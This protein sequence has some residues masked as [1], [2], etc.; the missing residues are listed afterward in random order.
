MKR[1]YFLIMLGMIILDMSAQ[2]RLKVDDIT[3]NQGEFSVYTSEDPTSAGVIFICHESIPLTFSSSLDKSAEPFKVE[4]EGSNIIYHLEFPT[5]KEYQRRQIFIHADN[6]DTFAFMLPLQ[7]SELMRFKVYDPN[8]TID[9][10]C[11]REHRNKGIAEMK[12]MN[13]TEARNQFKLAV[14]CDE[15]TEE[16]KNEIEK[17]LTDIDSVE[18][19]R[20]LG[21]N[22]VRLLDYGTAATY[23]EKA[24]KFNAN[25]DYSMQKYGQCLTIFNRECATTFN[26][27]EYYFNEKIY[28]KAKHLYELIVKDNCST[29]AIAI[30]RLNAIET[31]T[32]N[33]RDHSRVITYEYTKDTPI[34]FATGKYNMHKWGGFFHLN[35]NGEIFDLLRSSKKMGDAPEV[36]MTFGWTVKI[37]NPVWFFF[38]PGLTT[39]FYYGKYEKDLDGHQLYPGK[40]ALPQMKPNDRLAEF[41]NLDDMTDLDDKTYEGIKGFRSE[42]WDTNVAFAVTP[43]VGVLVKYS[44]FAL[45][46]SYQYRFVFKK[47]LEDFMHPSKLS[48]GLGIAF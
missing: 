41:L 31:V 32:T 45:R 1:F 23:Y 43:E 2:R 35:L 17:L 22:A 13:Y 26:Q 3:V 40:D 37:A 11:Y 6:F 46:L 16:E 34:G 36:N 18:Y 29:K 28:D 39:K 4:K 9:T 25:D 47:D 19:Y 27:A 44:W 12:T 14:L 24:Y 30:E 8:A 38:G 42:N 15:A 33:K 7:P 5:G 10:G 48:I 20:I 21:D